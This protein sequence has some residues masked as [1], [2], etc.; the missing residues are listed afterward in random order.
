MGIPQDILMNSD[1]ENDPN[2]RQGASRSQGGIIRGK[3]KGSAPNMADLCDCF[4]ISF[5][6]S[7]LINLSLL[8]AR[9]RDHTLPQQSPGRLFLYTLRDHPPYLT[10]KMA[11][12]P[13]LK[14]VLK[15]VEPV[16]KK[17]KG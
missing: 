5:K 10:R 11:T 14:D 15:T 1:E 16:F 6:Y 2:F 3:A 13:Y 17:I 8:L 4:I 12:F 7:L 9:M